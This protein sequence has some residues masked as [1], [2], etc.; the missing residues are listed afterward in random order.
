VEKNEKDCSM[1]S[2]TFRNEQYFF[3]RGSELGSAADL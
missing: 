2:V 3:S 1:D